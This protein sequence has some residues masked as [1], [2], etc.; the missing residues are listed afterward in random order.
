[1][2]GA[3]IPA[4]GIPACAPGNTND[5]VVFRD[6]CVPALVLEATA[7][8]TFDWDSLVLETPERPERSRR[9]RPRGAPRRS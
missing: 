5:Y 1:M 7:Y 9:R 6:P 4:A 8:L 3:G 2:W